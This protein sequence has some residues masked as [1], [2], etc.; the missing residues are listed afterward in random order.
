METKA[1]LDALDHE[2]IVAAIREAEA[3][4][5]GEV[6]VHVS[7]QP[8]TDAEAAAARRFEALAMT[9]TAERNGV[10]L[11][12]A[13]E[14]RVFAIVG[15]TGI[16]AHCGPGFWKDVAAAVEADFRGGRYTD[17]IV[18]G[19]ARVGDA[20]ARHFPRQQGVAD[21]NELPDEVTED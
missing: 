9:R 14:S 17:G 8:V 11:F 18:K 20:L 16:H 1:F 12:V 19:V 2:R 21:G 5:R 4:S 13:P 6:R 7:H 10:L 15:D 3:R